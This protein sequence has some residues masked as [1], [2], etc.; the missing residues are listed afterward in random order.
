MEI[1]QPF[2]TLSPSLTSAI[3]IKTPAARQSLTVSSLYQGWPTSNQ[4]IIIGVCPDK[5]IFSILNVS[6]RLWS[7]IRVDSCYSY[8]FP[9][10]THILKRTTLHSRSY[11]YNRGS[12]RTCHPWTNAIS[13]GR[14]ALL[15]A[16][17]GQ[18]HKTF[19]EL[20]GVSFSGKSPPTYCRL[21]S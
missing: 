17:V 15:R 13:I 6:C 20:A 10:I 8:F 1:N 14:S 18:S 4:G 21:G 12:A 3:I 2:L 16:E 9:A 7:L 5:G 11:N 19:C